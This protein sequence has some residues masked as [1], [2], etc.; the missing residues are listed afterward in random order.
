M[1]LLD[2]LS[3]I[4]GDAFA[5]EGLAASFGKVKVS[6]RPDLCQFQCNGPLAAAKESGAPPRAL[7]ERL[8]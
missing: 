5:A 1:T 2:E 7:A 8:V 3:R 6:D 4:V